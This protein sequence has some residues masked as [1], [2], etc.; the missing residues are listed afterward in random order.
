[1]FAAVASSSFALLG[2]L[3]GFLQRLRVLDEQ[4]EVTVKP[5]G[6]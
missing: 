1:L 3:E 5:L 2:G 4:F 6:V